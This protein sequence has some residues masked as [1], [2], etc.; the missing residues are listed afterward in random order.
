MMVLACLWDFGPWRE[1]LILCFCQGEEKPSFVNLGPGGTTDPASLV[2]RCRA[3]DLL[4]GSTWAWGQ[5][6]ETGEK[7][8]H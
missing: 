7:T 5:G 8:G 2:V 6:W 4:L 3:H 1:N